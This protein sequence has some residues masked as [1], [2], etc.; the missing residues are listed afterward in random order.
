VDVLFVDILHE[1]FLT[2]ALAPVPSST[3]FHA[4]CQP[5]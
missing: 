5:E 3:A 2:D 4:R 1:V